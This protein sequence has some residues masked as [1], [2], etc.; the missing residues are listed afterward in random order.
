ML[1]R[2][3]HVMYQQTV[4]APAAALTLR[5]ADPTVSFATRFMLF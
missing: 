4:M 3:D 5:E 2:S 1:K